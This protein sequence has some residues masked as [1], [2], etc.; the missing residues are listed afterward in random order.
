MD[1]PHAGRIFAAR[2]NG[3]IVGMVSLLFTISTA[4]GAKACWLEDMVVRPDQR[5]KGLGTRLLQHAISYAKANG[6]SRIAL[7]TDQTN[8]RA[9]RFYER[10]GFRA[11]VMIPLAVARV[12]R[13]ITSA[14]VLGRFAMRA[15][16]ARRGYRPASRGRWRAVCDP[17]SCRRLAAARKGSGISG[18]SPIRSSR[19]AC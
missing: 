12:V 6:F 1:D 13:L 18:P 9:I 11:L 14:I 5:G 3:Q 16:T 19:P 10:H 7:L 17:A 2:N 4:E 8:D 15:I